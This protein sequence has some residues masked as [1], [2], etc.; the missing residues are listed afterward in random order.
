MA[1]FKAKKPDEKL[2]LKIIRLSLNFFQ[3]LL[4][5]IGKP[6]Y[7]FFSY[8]LV[9]ILFSLYSLGHFVYGFFGFIFDLLSKIKIKRIKITLPKISLPKV[10]IPR[11]T[12][13]K[14]QIPRKK[15]V[16]KISFKKSLF[17][18]SI[19]GIIF[20]FWFFVLRG[21]PSPRKLVT[22]EQEISTKIY[23]RNGILLYKIYKE[24]NRT[25]VAL[26]KIPK[27]V[28]DATLAAEDA[29][30]YLHPGF[31]IKG[32]VRS[33]ISNIKKGR[34]S[35]GSTITQQ[36]VKNALLTPEKTLV[37]KI[38]ELILSVSAEL[39]F[40]KDQI[41][42]MYLNEVS[43]GGTAYGIEEASYAYFGKGVKDLNLAEA[44]LLAGLPKRPSTFSPFG[45]NPELAKERQKEVLNLMAINKFI[46]SEKALD[47]FNQKITYAPREIDIKAP[48][49]VMYVRQILADRYGEDVLQKGGLEV[50]TSL[51]YEIQKPVEKT[52]KEEIEKLRNFRVGNGAALVLNPLK[53]EI[54]AMVGSKDYFDT[55]AEGNVNVTTSLRQPGSSIKVINYAYA[56]G[57]GYTL[58]T[59]LD[60]SP[61]SFVIPGTTV[62][63]PKNYDGNYR[64][65]IPLR[66]ALAESRNIPAVKVLAS[67]GVTKMIV[68]GGKMGITSWDDPSRFGLSLTLGGG[69]VRLIDLARVYSTIANYGKRPEITPL[70]KVTDYKG[71]ILEET[72]GFENDKET[73]LDERIAFLLIDVLK[74]NI[75]RS[76][77]FGSSSS[78]VVKGHPEVAVKTGTS[79]NLKDNFTLGFNQDYLVAVWVGNN[80]S[81]PMSQIASGITGAAPIFNKIMTKLLEYQKAKEWTIPEGLEKIQI[82]SLTG[83]LP[84]EGCPSKYEWFLQETKPKTAC[85]IQKEPEDKSKILKEGAKTEN[86]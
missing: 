76:P 53:G 35:G 44:A 47:A 23:D 21:L 59:I 84:C 2:A 14:I 20:S 80:N 17:F 42:E 67:Y 57:H 60:D 40:S 37:R 62:Y 55:P 3:R 13:P 58:A 75:A 27:Y 31:S 28:I 71:K 78:L 85:V 26:S 7:L 52:V 25:P 54:L 8:G 65:K 19:L 74:D 81:S 43:Y 50:I 45:P 30:F 12:I 79:N 72:G 51:D 56:L 1:S 22:R 48:H 41:L 29:E 16:I 66:N 10:S 38:R 63:S 49:F 9:F 33:F 15:I 70:L 5:L 39:I 82:C 46:T 34:L 18:L 73:V 64:G 68:L 69:E 77:A 24:K 32:I 86:P 11:L 4:I 36:L 83:T 61:V 6:F